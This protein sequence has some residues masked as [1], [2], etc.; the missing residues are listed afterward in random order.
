MR[1]STALRF[2]LLALSFL[3]PAQ[4]V[5]QILPGIDRLH[6]YR[7]VELVILLLT[8]AVA[9]Q[10]EPG[11]RLPRA[12]AV[13]F[14]LGLAGWAAATLGSQYPWQSL[15]TGA[16]EFLLPFCVL[17]LF[18]CSAPDRDFLIS[19]G[20]LFVLGALVESVMQAWQIVSYYRDFAAANQLPEFLWL[21]TAAN[22]TT[23]KIA[24][25]TVLPAGL[26][27]F[28]YGNTD[29]YVSL[30]VLLVP[31][32]A[33]ATFFARR[34]WLAVAALFALLYF[35]LFT[36]SRSG[37]IVIFLSLAALLGI[38]LIANRSASAVI[39]ATLA[40]LI[41]IH[42]DHSNLDYYWRG[43]SGFANQASSESIGAPRLPEKDDAASKPEKN[44][45]ASKN[46]AASGPDRAGTLNQNKVEVEHSGPDPAG[47]PNQNELEF[48]RSGPDRAS[49]LKLGLNIG[50]RHWLTGI[51]YGVYPIIETRFTAPHSMLL[52]RFAE[53]GILGLISFLLL[54]LYAPFRLM[55][56][57]ARRSDMFEATCLLAVSAFMLKA[58][59]FGASFAISSNI[60]WGYAVMMVL[61]ASLVNDGA[62]DDAAN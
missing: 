22:F 59:V 29:N 16:L 18:L 43:V 46:D 38:N 57:L 35:G 52:L 34:R 30:W 62:R 42:I 36:Y 32:A 41:V 47:A 53:S 26:L 10:K 58:I 8:A 25:P 2:V 45:V 6:T 19:A 20:A 28:S 5:L 14:W 13:S 4:P 24:L 44:N 12:I 9:F 15:D 49:A 54:A 40:G 1:R 55:F 37:V 31:L 33:G 39:I 23:Y 27:P 51:G 56:L 60:V 17:Y 3:V 61:A 50:L 7:I 11:P 48:E 21:P